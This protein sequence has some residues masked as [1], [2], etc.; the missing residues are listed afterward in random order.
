MIKVDFM[1]LV[2]HE[3]REMQTALCL[4]KMLE[5]KGCTTIILSTEFHAHLYKKYK[6]KTVVFPYWID[7]KTRQIIPFKRNKYKSTN[8]VSLNW[9]QLLSGANKDFKKPKSKLIK[10]KF[11]HLAWDSSFKGF[12]ESAGVKT[13]NIDIIGNPLHELLFKDLKNK[14]KYEIM[15]RSDFGIDSKKDIFFFPMNYGWAFFNDDKLK[16]KIKMGYPSNIAY[17][18]REYSS[19]CLDSFVFFVKELC[20]FY[21]DCSFILRPHPSISVEQYL[22]RFKDNNVSLPKNLIVT[23]KYTIR[24]WISISKIV[25][26]SWSTSVWDAKKIGKVGFLYT[27]YNRPEWL[28]TNWNSIV[29][30][31]KSLGEFDEVLNSYSASDADVDSIINNISSWLFEIN[32]DNSSNNFEAFSLFSFVGFKYSLRSFFRYSSMRFFKGLGV[33]KGLRRDFFYPVK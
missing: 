30:N 3:D 25:G 20:D 33:N 15:I 27:P 6:P 8:F 1:I 10:E 31:I 28:E 32:R 2:E 7:D 4:K 22:K 21:N 11:N 18:Y 9:E 19:K 13:E 12:L 5:I 24:E 29:P 14:E 16:A 23:K 26:S 17:E